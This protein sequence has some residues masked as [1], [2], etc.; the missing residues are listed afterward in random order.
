MKKLTE[1][2][3]ITREVDSRIADLVYFYQYVIKNCEGRI[4]F[5]T[6]AEDDERLIKLANE[7]WDMQHGED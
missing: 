3:T 4:T 7:F 6:L 5:E 2:V 1:T